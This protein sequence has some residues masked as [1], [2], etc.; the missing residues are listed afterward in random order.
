MENLLFFQKSFL[1]NLSTLELKN[2]KCWPKMWILR[3]MS[4]LEPAPKVR[5][6]KSRFKHDRY[7][8]VIKND[9][10]HLLVSLKDLRSETLSEGGGTLEL[11]CVQRS[12]KTD[13][14]IRSYGLS[15]V[16]IIPC[17]ACQRV[18][19][20]PFKA[21]RESVYIVAWNASKGSI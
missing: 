20:I 9:F 3:E 17:K 18:D 5:K 12:C 14:G 2:K 21:F 13:G 1:Y 19:I 11:P 10:P 8:L 16:Y 7:V 6:P 4:S 15:R